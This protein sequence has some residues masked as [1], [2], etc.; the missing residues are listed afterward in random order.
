M[1]LIDLCSYIKHQSQN[2]SGVY[3]VPSVTAQD[4]IN[5]VKYE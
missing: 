2:D 1:K 4:L 3:Y 5:E